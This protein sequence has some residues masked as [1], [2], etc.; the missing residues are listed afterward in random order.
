MSNEVAELKQKVERLERRI[1]ELEK[2]HGAI[3]V[4]LKSTEPH[5]KEAI[6]ALVEALARAAHGAPHLNPEE[7]TKIKKLLGIG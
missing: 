3:S 6:L 1:N 5:I 4:Y 7:Q 2:E